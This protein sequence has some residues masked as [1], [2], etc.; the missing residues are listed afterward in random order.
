MKKRCKHKLFKTKTSSS[1]FFDYVMSHQSY[2]EFQ[3]AKE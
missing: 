2:D 3:I 1:L